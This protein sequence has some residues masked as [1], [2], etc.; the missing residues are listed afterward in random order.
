[1]R[2][3]YR[4]R[5]RPTTINSSRVRKL[6]PLRLVEQAWLAFLMGNNFSA[7]VIFLLPFQQGKRIFP[8]LRARHRDLAISSVLQSVAEGLDL[9]PAIG[10]RVESCEYCF[11]RQTPIIDKSFDG[12][13]F[14]G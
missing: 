5:C 9:A 14:V 8:N 1:M 13:V 12:E 7:G 6:V 10:L 4:T 3:L 2:R 11:T